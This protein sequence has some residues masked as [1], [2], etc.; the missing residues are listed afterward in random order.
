MNEENQINDKLKIM[1]FSLLLCGLKDTQFF[2][3]V[4]YGHGF[5][6]CFHFMSFLEDMFGEFGFAFFLTDNHARFD[7]VCDHLLG[8]FPH[9]K[10]LSL[11][12]L[13]ARHQF[14]VILLRCLHIYSNSLFF[15]LGLTSIRHL[16]LIDLYKNNSPFEKNRTVKPGIKP[17]I[18]WSV[19]KDFTTEP[20]SQTNIF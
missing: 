8:D 10:M 16:E 13:I 5:F 4:Y 12:Q 2:F 20:S 15:F 9:S 7:H 6:Y 14:F 11:Y 1:K 18:P 3:K 17:G 19:G